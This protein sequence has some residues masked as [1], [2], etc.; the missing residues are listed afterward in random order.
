M[1]KTNEVQSETGNLLIAGDGKYNLTSL[2]S[3]GIS[4]IAYAICLVIGL[5]VIPDLIRTTRRGWIEFVGMRF[6]IQDAQSMATM[7]IIIGLIGLIIG[8]YFTIL[9][10]R[11]F[12]SEIHVYDNCIIGKNVQG[13][14]PALQ[15]FNVPLSDVKNVDV[16]KGTGITIH[17]Q[18]GTYTSYTKNANEVRD[19]IMANL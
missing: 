8:M 17:T 1:R 12:Q 16:L 6:S 7:F 9:A 5:V 19:I 11:R 10:L 14:P 13:M 2:I 15:E 4:L 3:W 18:Y